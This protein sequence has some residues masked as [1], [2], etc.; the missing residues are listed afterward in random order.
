MVKSGNCISC[1]ARGEGPRFLAAG[2][3]Y[4][5][6]DEPD[7][8][9]G[10]KGVVVQLTDAKN[11]VYKMTSNAAGNFTLRRGGPLAFPIGGM[12]APQMTA[13]CAACHTAS[14]ANGAPGR[15]VAP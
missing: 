14:G 10:V 5:Q 12:T 2:T 15:V 4:Q 9:Y 8:C 11:K 1:H 7:D 13:S 3:V 6:L